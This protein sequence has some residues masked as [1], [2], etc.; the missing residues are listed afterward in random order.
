LIKKAWVFT[1]LTLKLI[2]FTDNSLSFSIAIKYAHNLLYKSTCLRQ[3]S[4]FYVSFAS[5]STMHLIIMWERYKVHVSGTATLT[6]SGPTLK[7]IFS[8]VSI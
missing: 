5:L 2:W 4:V 6:F 1:Q 7:V 8:L 3:T